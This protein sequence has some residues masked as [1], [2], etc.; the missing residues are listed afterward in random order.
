MDSA[1]ESNAELEYQLVEFMR[2]V[3]K[4]REPEKEARTLLEK[5][6]GQ[7]TR[8]RFLEY[9]TSA[10]LNGPFRKIG[11]HHYDFAHAD[12]PPYQ[13]MSHPISHY[14]IS[15]SHNTYCSQDQWSGKSDA[16]M[17][18]KV[19]LAGCRCVEIDCWDGPMDEPIVYH[20]YT[21][22]RIQ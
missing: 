13:D 7:L 10:T 4:E 1:K 17:Y 12:C 15:S 3:Q 5:F 11:G 8:Q 20:G 19:L 21:S 9:L 14:F 6:N 16:D 18:R 22:L 2:N